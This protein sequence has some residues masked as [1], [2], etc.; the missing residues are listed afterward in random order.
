MIAEPHP[1]GRSSLILATLTGNDRVADFSAYVQTDGQ[2][3]RLIRDWDRTHS[4]RRV[5]VA[6]AKSRIRWARERTVEGGNTVSRSLNDMLETLGDVPEDRPANFVAALL[7]AVEGASRDGGVDPILR[8]AGA[9]RWPPLFDVEP[10]LAG[11]GERRPDVDEST[12][13]SER[14]ALLL[15]AAKGLEDVREALTG[16]VSNLLEDAAAGLWLD[17]DD[18]TAR[19]VLDLARELRAADEAETLPWVARILGMQVFSTLSAMATQQGM[20]PEQFARALQAQAQNEREGAEAS[21]T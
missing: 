2:R 17:G 15:E 14:E 7:E 12:P 19:A 21:A 8:A 18:A 4:G 11:V 1:Q 20:S 5:P 3:E 13:E 16:P 10:I 6:W 9:H